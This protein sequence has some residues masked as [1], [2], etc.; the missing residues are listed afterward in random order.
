MKTEPM[1]FIKRVLLQM[2][3]GEAAIDEPAAVLKVAEDD[4]YDCMFPVIQRVADEYEAADVKIEELEIDL[5]ELTMEEVPFQLEKSLK[6]ALEQHITPFHNDKTAFAPSKQVVGKASNSSQGSHEQFSEPYGWQ[7]EGT[8]SVVARHHHLP[9]EEGHVFAEEGGSLA[10]AHQFL[11][12]LGDEQ[13]PWTEEPSHFDADNWCGDEIFSLL[14]DL[15]FSRS[16]Y[17]QCQQ[18]AALCRLLMYGNDEFLVQ[19]AGQWLN[20]DTL[21]TYQLRE[22]LFHHGIMAVERQ[23]LPLISALPSALLRL[24]LLILVREGCP[25]DVQLNDSSMELL[26]KAFHELYMEK[27]LLLTEMTLS[28]REDEDQPEGLESIEDDMQAIFK[29]FLPAA[30]QMTASWK[31]HLLEEVRDF[32]KTKASSCGARLTET[33][34]SIREDEDQPEGISTF[35]SDGRHYETDV[36]GIV[37]L[38][39]FLPIFFQRVGLLDAQNRFLSLEKQLHAVH[40]LRYL[41]G[42][43]QPHQSYQLVLEKIVCGLPPDFPIPSEYEVGDDEKMEISDLFGAVR[44]YWR[45]VSETSTPGIQRSFIHRQGMACFEEPYW[46]L[47][48]EESA[49]DILMDEIPWELS[50][51]VLPWCEFPVWVEWQNYR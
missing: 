49:V 27:G 1:S 38:H 21:H 22:L 48:V 11:L 34:L 43:N 50:M 30:E 14:S 32:G 44:Q 37:L 8:S 51:L 12:F 31:K 6:K 45:A 15:N 26:T 29:P 35:M 19:V 46:V 25:T 33:T 36:A 18:P 7:V 10:L 20:D 13:L 3:Y 28:V 2:R 40:L 24:L 9:G 23:A 41:A 4:F 39:P 5:G 17:K 47:R 16:I 42:K